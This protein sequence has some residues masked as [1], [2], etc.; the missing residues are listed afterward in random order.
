MV[1]PR[2]LLT[3]KGDARLGDEAVDLAGRA[4]LELDEWQAFVLRESLRTRE[5]GRWSAFEV[6]VNVARQNGKGGIIE[7]RILAELYL[8][9]SPLTIY[10]AHNFD[11]SLEHFR[12]V[13]FLVEE[14]P[15]LAREIM[16]VKGGRKYGITFGHGKEG[17]E[18]TG[19]RRLRFRTRTKGGGRGFSCDCLILDECM[20]MPEWTHGALFPTV[21]AREN[22]QIWYLG[23][24]VDQLI[25]EHG[26]VFANVRERA[27]A[28]DDPGL[29]YFE[30]SVEENGGPDHVDE[31]VAGDQ[32]AW[33]QANPALGIRITPE[34]VAQERRAMDNRTFAVERLGIGDWPRTDHVS[35]VIDIEAWN[36]LEDGA[37]RLQD[38]VFLAFDVSPDRTASIAA[39]G[40]NQAGRW[41]VEVID[42]K[43]GTGWVAVRLAEL[44]KKH[45]AAGVFCDAY[46]PAG[47]VVPQVEE[48]GVEIT[49][50][51][52]G[53]HAQAC[54]R[55]VD[56]I[57]E[58]TLRSSRQRGTE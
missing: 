16:G 5:G 15:E 45:K 49:P 46:G 2:I 19:N 58:G 52:A 10:S 50:L 38:P 31:G 40:L 17:I 33:A 3:Q 54:G 9:K 32:A 14:T 20:F 43:R 37:S 25:H 11:T 42:S 34:Y 28:G 41:H 29:A 13:E 21:S 27:V 48:A 12:R 18:L 57:E 6:G 55:L 51:S 39:A 35:G 22:P 26:V 8:V 1:S 30:W 36:E 44:V 47:S 24:A 4:G 53:E 7:A 56:A 23:T